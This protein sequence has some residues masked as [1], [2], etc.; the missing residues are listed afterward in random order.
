MTAQGVPFFR[1][2]A[3]TVGQEIKCTDVRSA[4]V[5]RKAKAEVY[6][7]T[8]PLA[9]PTFEVHELHLEAEGQ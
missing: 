6:T 7:S 5:R 2:F 8:P 3:Y 1:S 4:S 9:W